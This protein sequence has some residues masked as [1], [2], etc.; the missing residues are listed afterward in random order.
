MPNSTL[1]LAI[2]GSVIS[3]IAVTWNVILHLRS[4]R[5]KLR[6]T[7]TSNTKLPISNSGIRTTAFTTLDISVVN[8]SEKTRYVKQPQFELDQSMNKFMNILDLSNPVKY[9]VQ[10]NPGEE[11]SVW[12]NLDN[13]NHDSL[14]KIVAKKFRINIVDTHGKEHTTKWY[15]TKDFYLTK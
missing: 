14:D 2:Y 1:Y 11:F 9:P 3:T 12:F 10:L 8:L 13:L 7:P 15:N 5:G 6:I 4:K